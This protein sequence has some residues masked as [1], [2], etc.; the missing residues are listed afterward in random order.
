[1]CK[2]IKL[3]NSSNVARFKTKI[4]KALLFCQ[5]KCK[6]HTLGSCPDPTP[7]NGRIVINEG[8]ILPSGRY[9][10]SSVVALVCNDGYNS[11]RLRPVW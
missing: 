8:T 11:T 2:M 6:I 1:M 4:G 9:N 10:V 5:D 7:E 3:L